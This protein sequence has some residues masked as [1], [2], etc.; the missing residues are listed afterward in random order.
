MTTPLR[1]LLIEDAEDDALL[2]LRELRRGGY[3]VVSERV[4]TADAMADALGRGT[5]DIVLCDYVLPRFSGM[6][7]LKL[8]QDLR[9][10]VP[11]LMVSGEA[12]EELAVTA[13][14]AGA[15]D[16]L[17]KENLWRLVPA[18][19]RA[20]R[21]ATERRARQRAEADKTALLD[22]VRDLSASLDRTEILDRMQR[23]VAALLPCDQV[24]TFQ[25]DRRRG[26]FV[27]TAL[28]GI[29]EPLQAAA[30]AVEFVRGQPV[31]ERVLSGHTVLVNDTEGQMS[32]APEL[33]EQFGIAAVLG[34]P[35]RRG[36]TWS[37]SLPL[38]NSD[39]G[40]HSTGAPCSCSKGS[41]CTSR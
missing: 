27:A 40:T 25:W 8:L 28:Y 10:D 29:P 23:R 3:E 20:L 26:A 34:V 38:R 1:V 39:R 9:R 37:V 36:A 15:Q 31:V 2:C 21:E 18:V 11:A 4:E 33:L 14:K 19:Q 32:F 22:L 30:F 5:W 41:P 24:A 17:L 7:A 13:M 35:L 16:Y 6:A 12:G